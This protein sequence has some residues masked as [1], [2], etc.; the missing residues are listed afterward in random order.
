MTISNPRGLVVIANCH[1]LAVADAMA[2]GA[3][4]VITDFID[5]SFSKEPH[6][7]EKIDRCFSK[8]APEFLLSFNLSEQ[9]ERLHTPRLRAHFGSRLTV[10]SNLHFAG[11]HPDITYIGPM[12][13]RIKGFLGDYHSKLVLFSFATRYSVDKCLGLFNGLTYEKLG[14][15]DEFQTSAAELIQRDETCD[16]KFGATFL[17]ILK[18]EPSLYTINHPTGP[19]FIELSAR[20]ASYCGLDFVAT[21]RVNFQNHLSNNYIWP[22]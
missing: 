7:V 18:S 5:I 10:F 3:R 19:V 12:G 8:D 13:H 22:V 14:F 11:L 20:L 17:D 6:M 9:F 21:S 1:S 16:V 15:F 4:H 2:I